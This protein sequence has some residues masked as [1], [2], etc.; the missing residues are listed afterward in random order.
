MQ[1]YENNLVYERGTCF[2]ASYSKLGSKLTLHTLD[3]HIQP[4]ELFLDS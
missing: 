3:T 4:Y 1:G 2:R